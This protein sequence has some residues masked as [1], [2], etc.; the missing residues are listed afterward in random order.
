M[1]VNLMWVAQS[2]GEIFLIFRN[3]K[4]RIYKLLELSLEEKC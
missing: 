3:R 2:V 1:R 4:N